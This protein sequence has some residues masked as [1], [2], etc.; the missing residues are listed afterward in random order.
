MG[1][2]N[3]INEEDDVSSK[4]LLVGGFD[5]SYDYSQSIVKLEI[6]KEEK[7]VFVHKNIKGLPIGDESS[8]WYEKEFHVMNNETKDGLIAVNF[9][10]FNN[11]FV[12]DFRSCEFK[13]YVNQM[14][15]GV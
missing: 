7:Y 11:I 13:L 3:L 4:I 12:Y 10:C 1:I 15:R 8:F 14:T 2:I 5:Q 9:N 6:Y